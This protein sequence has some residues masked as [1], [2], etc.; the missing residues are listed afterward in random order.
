MNMRDYSTLHLDTN[1]S[2]GTGHGYFNMSES[3]LLCTDCLLQYYLCY[4]HLSHIE[5]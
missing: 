3:K 5:L 2:K 4:Y 1:S